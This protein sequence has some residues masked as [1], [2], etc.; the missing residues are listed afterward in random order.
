M[1]QAWY[2]GAGTGLKAFRRHRGGR[3]QAR[4]DPGLAAK[5]PRRPKTLK[6]TRPRTVTKATV[7]LRREMT[8]PESGAAL[9]G[10]I[11]KSRACLRVGPGMET[12]GET[13]PPP[14]PQHTHLAPRSGTHYSRVTVKT[15]LDVS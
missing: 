7:P 6:E 2:P 5:D 4:Q 1:G 14:A 3:K 13:K 9:H 10:E 15:L 11:A 12:V 8:R